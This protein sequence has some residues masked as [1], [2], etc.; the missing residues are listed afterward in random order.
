MNTVECAC[1]PAGVLMPSRCESDELRPE[2][3]LA[4]TLPHQKNHC[5][6]AT[7]VLPKVLR[8]S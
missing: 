3:A 8:N 1:L 2:R 6:S 5:F 7:Q 4:L